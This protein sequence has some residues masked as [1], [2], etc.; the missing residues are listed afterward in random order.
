M[1]I[2]IRRLALL[3]GATACGVALG[4]VGTEVVTAVAADAPVGLAALGIGTIV[5]LVVVGALDVAALASAARSLGDDRQSGSEDP[6]GQG[7]RRTPP[8]SPL[9]RQDPPGVDARGTRRP[10]GTDAP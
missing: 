7:G 2:R 5:V 6:M 1:A 4:L 9:G 10:R 8:A 3:V